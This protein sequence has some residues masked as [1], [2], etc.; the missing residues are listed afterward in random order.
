MAA[1]GA[2]G[3]MPS[4]P[5]AP[6]SL[7]RAWASDT[8][9]MTRWLPRYRREWLRGDLMAG[10]IVAA[11]LVP[12]SL[13]YARIA[14]VPVEIGL[15]AVPLA[16]VAYA[17][18]GSSRQLVV[19]PASTV[20]IVSGSL[21]L[22]ITR[23]NPEDAVAVTAA[24][25]IACGVVL[26]AA[27]VL[28]VAWL[29]EFLSKPVI[30]GFVFGLTLTIVIGEVPALLG[31]DKPPGDLLGVL[32]RTIGRVGDLHVPTAVT[33]AVALLALAG[34]RRVLPRLPWGLLTVVAAV[35][36]SRWLG[37]EDAGVA[38]IGEVPRGLPP[39]AIPTFPREEIGAV[40]VGGASL[41]LV[42]LAEGLAASRLFATQGGYRVET[43]R[44]LVGMGA[45]NVAAGLSGGLAV[46]GSLSKTAAAAQAG[47]RTQVTGL[48]SAGLVVVVLL[49]FTWVVED[50]PQ[51]VLAAVV[52]AAVW[53]LM[54]V[55]AIRRYA[56]VR[57]ADL[58][59]ALVG[60]AAV[61]LTGPLTGLGITIAV[62]LSAIIYRAS[63]ASIEVLGRIGDE[64]AAWGRLHGHPD[65]RPVPGV[66]VVR[67]D[68]P[69]F[70]GNATSIEQRILAAA[71]ARPDTRALVLDLE[72]TTQLDTT[73][74]DV[75]RHLAHELDGRGVR[76]YLARVLHRV[77]GVLDR[78][79]V[80]RVLGTGT[81][82]H[83]IS[84][85]V[86]AARRDTGLKGARTSAGRDGAGE[87]D[88]AAGTSEDA[89]SGDVADARDLADGAGDAA[90]VVVLD[91]DLGAGGADGAVVRPGR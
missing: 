80:T 78:A 33:G 45:A 53:G 5:S 3:Q 71:E 41:A 6:P 85:A 30:T 25:A 10:V 89:A 79:G 16:L 77:E 43:E 8:V 76:L 7:E 49:A 83:S 63:S 50:L 29:A 46:A 66:V 19:G 31:I 56:H 44:E 61:V 26:V 32:T 52:I 9:P 18:L 22:D 73:S 13:G 64:K 11:L 67:L 47:G 42:A 28:R 14:N 34:G 23:G 60:I 57:R 12:Q 81:S 17:V 51:A 54:D 38:V 4:D 20:A 15:Y 55:A 35:V 58:V 90:E 24:L 27:G 39:L 59:A 84:Q 37:L 40:L 68:A 91:D 36:A 74:A 69:L 65:R 88:D 72:A 1:D 62:S 21:V 87:G 48:A 86:R 82:W 75:I 70:W 2:D